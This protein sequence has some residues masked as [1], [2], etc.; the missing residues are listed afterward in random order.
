MTNSTLTPALYGHLHHLKILSPNPQA[1]ARFY[2]SSL[3]MTVSAVGDQ[4]LC[5]GPERGLI[6]AGG[7]TGEL[8]FAAYAARDADVLTGLVTRLQAAGV[9]V[10]PFATPLLLAGSIGFSDPD[11]NRFVFGLPTTTSAAVV[12]ALPARL[13]HVVFA[14]TNAERMMA[15]FRD[16]VGFRLS[17]LVV[18]AE[19]AMRTCFLRTD[20]EHHSLAIFQADTNRLDHHCYESA[21][22]NSIR[23]WGDHFASLHLQVQWGPGRHGPGNNLFVFVHDPDGN[24]VEISAELEV[25]SPDRTVGAWPH[26]ERTLNSWGKGLLRS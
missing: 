1:L 2:G 12:P 16:V 17:D 8:G 24:W 9:A 26:E 15:F 6:I 18:D 20:H 14:S 5:T 25:V 10:E 19:E 13:Q 21:D 22:W 4:W 23:D 3:G 11:G 7:D